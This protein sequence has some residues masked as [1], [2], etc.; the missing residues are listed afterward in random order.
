M[1]FWIQA[2]CP[3]RT[4]TPDSA[5]GLS[6]VEAIEAAFPLEAED[7][8][9]V[10]NGVSIRLSY[11]YDM[12]VIIEELLNLLS[13]LLAGADSI[14]VLFGSDTFFANWEL[15]S[16]DG[17]VKI[18]ADWQSALASIEALR[19]AP[20]VTLPLLDFLREWCRPL[21]LVHQATADLR[22]SPEGLSR[23]HALAELVERIGE[24]GRLYR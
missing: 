24:E 2:G 4:P 6:L 13:K 8:V 15:E 3:R 14:N 7:L 9:L 10:W 1:S 21:R 11:K 12:S 17:E 18:T 22:L 20:V 16:R 19:A 23:S 5:G